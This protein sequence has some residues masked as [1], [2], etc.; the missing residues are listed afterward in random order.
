MSKELL[1]FEESE[2]D[3]ERRIAELNAASLK[4]LLAITKITGIRL[5]RPEWTPDYARRRQKYL[6]YINQL[7]AAQSLPGSEDDWPTVY[8]NTA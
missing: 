4:G 8:K 1:G 7:H 5:V 3:D 6:D 2:E